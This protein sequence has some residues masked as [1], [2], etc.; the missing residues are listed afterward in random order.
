M[1][2]QLLALALMIMSFGMFSQS[3]IWA[4]YNANVDSFN[5]TGARYITVVD[6]NTV[7]GLFYDGTYTTRTINHF[8]RTADGVNFVSGAFLPDTNYFNPSNIVAVND[9]VAMIACYSKDATRNGIIMMT[10]DS[11]K[12]WSNIADT[13]FMFVGSN[14][15]PD[16]VHFYSNTNGWCLGDPNGNTGGGATNEFEIYQTTNMGGTWTRVP[17]ANIPNPQSGEYGLTNVYTTLGTNEIW[18]GTNKGRVYHSSNGGT[19]WT[20]S[21]AGLAGGVQGLAFRDAMNGMVWGSTSTT[22]NVYLLKKTND[23]GVTWTAVPTNT[24]SIGTYD[25]SAIPGRAAYMSVGINGTGTSGTAYVTSVTTDDGNTWNILEQGTTNTERMLKVVMLDSAHGWAGS[26][27]DQTTPYLYGMDKYIGPATALTC[28]MNVSGTATICSGNAV[29]LTASGTSTYTWSANA[30]SAT[31]STVSVSPSTSTV[32]TVSGTVSTCT[33]TTTFSVTVNATP[34]VVATASN[35][36]ICNLNSTSMSATGAT[37][38][39]WTGAGLASTSGANVSTTTYTAAGTY[40]Y[41]VTGTTSG[42]NGVAT[43]TITVLPCVGINEAA[44]AI[45]SIYPNPS[46]GNVTVNFGKAVAGTKVVVTDMIGNQVYSANVNN[47]TEKINVDLTSM[48]KGM[49][50]ITVK[51]NSASVLKKLI[52]E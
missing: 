28:P 13:S 32:Y 51:N 25:I 4:P 18:F 24:T 45:A 8:N 42:C 52:I 9:S 47:G 16:V 50:L 48:P 22:S 27:T 49:Y 10:M 31:T 20:V 3:T 14:N 21:S 46:A 2:K 26:F 34:T 5:T 17:D 36:T 44:D 23:G 6:T 40:T 37:S 35:Y 33:N 15:F 12:T 11:G 43:V 41:N 38:Y 39:N 29:T 19:N 1:K 7:W 30:G